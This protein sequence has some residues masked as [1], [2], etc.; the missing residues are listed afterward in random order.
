MKDYQ[1]NDLG[2]LN[3]YD[4][5]K[6][7][8]YLQD[9]IKRYGKCSNIFWLLDKDLS[10]YCLKEVVDKIYNSIK[11]EVGFV[12]LDKFEKDN[13]CT[14]IHLGFGDIIKRFFLDLFGSNN[15]NIITIEDK[16]ENDLSWLGDVKVEVIDRVGIE[17]VQSKYFLMAD[18]EG[19]DLSTVD[20]TDV[21][22]IRANLK[23]T[24]ARI[25][26]Q[27][28]G[29]N[30]L[31][32]L[33]LLGMCLEGCYVINNFSGYPDNF[34]PDLDGVILVD[35]FDEIEKI[36]IKRDED[37]EKVNYINDKSSLYHRLLNN[38]FELKKLNN[39]EEIVYI[40]GLSVYL[41]DLCPMRSI[42]YDDTVKK[43]KRL[44]K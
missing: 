13:F 30:K 1:N 18:L 6:K 15:E 31:G 23:N 43:I 39:D 21:C 40:E 27:K 29:K 10:N 8:V 11:Q 17:N 12:G 35:S 2:Y 34:I 3:K 9:S 33:S 32:H 5:L 37:G 28:I 38:K 19:I 26:P 7:Y 16:K 41:S 24:G 36:E 20:F 42:L 22:L 4:D 44:I 14:T 25:D